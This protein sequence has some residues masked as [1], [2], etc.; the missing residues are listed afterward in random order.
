MEK[1][2]HRK[3][4]K[5][6]SAGFLAFT[7]LASSC[8]F[9][10]RQVFAA[11]S[12]SQPLNT[13]KLSTCRSLAL[14]NSDSRDSAEDKVYQAQAKRDSSIKALKLKKR[15]L[16]TFR[17]SPLL[18][19]HF[20][21][22]LTEQQKADFEYKP[23]QLQSAV[24][25]AQHN[26]QDKIFE[27]NEK[28]NTL[29]V[30]I[31]SLQENI[32]FNESRLE[33]YEDGLKRNKARLQ[34]GEANQADIDKLQK[35]VD[36]TTQ[37]IAA[38][39]RTLEADLKKLS[40]MINLDVTTGYKFEKPYVEAKIT[41]DSLPGLI[42]YT[43]DRDQ[44]YY[45]ACAN[46]TTAKLELSINFD[47]LKGYYKSKDVNIISGYINQVL[48]DREI[49]KKAFKKAYKQFLERIDSYWEG[50]YKIHLLF[51]TIKFPKIYLKGDFDGTRWIEED[52]NVVEEQ[53]LNYI[54]ARNDEIAA[55]EE[56]D[57][58]VEDTFNNYVSV[59][60]SYEQSLKD[61]DTMEKQLKEYAVK[62][63]MGEMTFQEYSDAQD[64]YEELQNTMHSNMAL[65]TTTL[66]NFDRLTCG[67][68]SALLSGTDSDMHTAVVGES[69]LDKNSSRIQYFLKPIIQREMF[70]LSIFVPENFEGEITDFEFWCDNEMIGERTPKDKELRHL[71]LTT[72]NVE[73]TFIRLYDGE[74]FVDDCEIDSSVE[75]DYL[76]VT[77][78]IDVKK[79]QNGEIGTYLVEVSTV[80]GLTSLTLK[81]DEN[82]G[83]K[84]F[85]IMSKDGTPLG[86]GSRTEISK[87]FTHLGLVASDLGELEIEFYDDSD[88]LKYKGRFDTTTQKL[89]KKDN[90]TE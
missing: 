25:V 74:K 71:M 35:K 61:V 9:G 70:T 21:Q 26:F 85:R 50:V 83:I 22:K 40:K 53:A 44:T 47:L 14:E 29:Y 79:D 15:N 36:S 20:P 77:T 48:N 65:Y 37:K 49:S 24:D 78:S 88:S 60:N 41:R 17:W 13:I 51:F 30:E 67:G 69:Y 7:I 46:A 23:K 81:P 84:S 62:N 90:L 39:R 73:K 1:R 57:Q 31:V 27:V 75:S 4:Y 34:T 11:G 5:R 82:E 59:R 86:D 38:D 87:K 52:P 68:I 76:N 45:E 80:T 72:E 33:T 12:G 43:E 2:A 56:L 54:S 89:K 18:S 55:R 16:T 58:M 8:T 10:Q 28:T 66:F 3:L 32:A 64:Q 6:I 63:K 19:F 42:T